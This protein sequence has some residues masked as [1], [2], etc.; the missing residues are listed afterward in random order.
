MR[1]RE[2]EDA[3]RFLRFFW[4]WKV[5]APPALRNTSILRV[6]QWRTQSYM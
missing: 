2:E 4:T 6:I 5:I 3:R 1:V